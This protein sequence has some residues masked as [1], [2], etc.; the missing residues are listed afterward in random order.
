M[1]ICECPGCDKA[2]EVE[3]LWHFLLVCL[4][5]SVER[6][7]FVS[8]VM[9]SDIL[10]ALNARLGSIAANPDTWLRRHRCCCSG[11]HVRR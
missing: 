4:R 6:A 10:P 5:W 2:H 11:R 7:L 3:S 8:N 1:C 9:L